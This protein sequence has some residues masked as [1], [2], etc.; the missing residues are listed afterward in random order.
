MADTAKD[1]TQQDVQESAD[2]P[3]KDIVDNPYIHQMAVMK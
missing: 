3:A 1:L 2:T